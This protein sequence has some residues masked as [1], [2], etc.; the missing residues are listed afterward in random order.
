MS[1]GDSAAHGADPTPFQQAIAKVLTEL[2]PEPGREGLKDTPRRVEK[3]FRFYTEGY[4]RDPKEVIGN[5]LFEAETD[6]M[7]VVKNIEL[8]SL[9]EHHLAPFFGK[10]HVAYIPSGKIV[11]LSKI[12]RVVD[13]FARRLQ[14]QE[15]L[16]MQ[17]AQA[18]DEVMKPRG[19]A[20]VIEASHLCMMM[21]GVEKQN[22]STVTSCLLGLF[23]K[24][25]RTRTEFLKLIRS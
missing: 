21:R 18:I 3:A 22:S 7:V 14:V 10:A 2:D 9:C 12:A 4:R 16:T 20:V 23:R 13:I 25:E 1:A 15:R 19:V 6:E 24:D 5:A 8:Y 17:V 11:G